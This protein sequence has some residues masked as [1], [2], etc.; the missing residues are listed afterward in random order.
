MSTSPIT[1]GLVIVGSQLS[2]H[3]DSDGKEKQKRKI[4]KENGST[5]QYHGNTHSKHA[6]AQNKKRGE[7]VFTCI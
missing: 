6:R 3:K 2:V 5:N 1:Q 4:S 7:G